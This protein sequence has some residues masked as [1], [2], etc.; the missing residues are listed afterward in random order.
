MSEIIFRWDG[1]AFV[2]WGRF[3]KLCDKEYVIGHDYRLEAVNQRS[4]ATHNHFF[5]AIAS[6]FENL[7]EDVAAQFASP[8]HLRKYALIKAGFADERSIVAS[9]KAETLRIAAFVKPMDEYAMVTV[10][11]AVI[12]VYT[13]QSQSMKAMGKADFQA[14]KQACLEIVSAMIGVKPEDLSREA[15]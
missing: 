12:K 7:P 1:E 14:S 4:Q 6:A 8:E 9:S 13:A 10:K 15:A 2:P 11:G 5:A 3:Q